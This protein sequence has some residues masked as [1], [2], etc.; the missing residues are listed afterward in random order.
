MAKREI[1]MIPAT[2]PKFTGK[3]T[4]PGRKRR[5]AAYARVS[6]DMEEQQTSYEAQMDYYEKYIIARSDWDF[7]GLYSDEGI[8]GTS[9]KYRTGFNQMIE[10]ALAGKIDLIVTKSISRFARNTVDSLVTIRK[11][12]EHG[13]EC[14][15][16][17]ENIYTFDSKGELLITIMSSIAQEESR[18]I[19]ENVTWG[20]R[21]R[22]ADGKVSMPYK[23][24]LG[25]S[26]GPDGLPQVVEKEAAVVRSIYLMFLEGYSPTY[27]AKTLT[28]KGIP[29]PAG[30]KRWQN[31]TVE[32]ILRNEKYKGDALLQK[33]F[34]VDF[35]T[36]KMKTNEGEIPQ[37]YVTDS[38]EGIISPEVFELA[39]YEFQCR[40]ENGGSQNHNV[41]PFSGH[42]ICGECGAYYGHKVWHSNDKYRRLVWLC[43]KKYGKGAGDG[44]RCKTPHLTD[45]EVKTF[46]VGAMNAA[47][48][49]KQEILDNCRTAVEFLTDT[50]QLESDLRK[51]E[52]ECDVATG[53]L[54]KCIDENAH[55]AISQEDYETKYAALAA[56][57]EA[58]KGKCDN[59]NE[60]ILQR[61]LKANRIEAF[62]KTMETSD[63]VTEFDEGLWN[64]TVDSL[65]VYSKK[66]IVLKLKDGTEIEWH[67]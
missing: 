57:Y 61:K 29:T 38:H 33:R 4:M 22:F 18:S 19:S 16:E 7:A 50:S 54:R 12:K 60:K 62:F 20:Q 63:I 66:K 13:V 55:A 67:I 37:Y 32:S 30:K 35:L 25:Y 14:F 64:A 26:K 24:F 27:I 56:R 53:L 51:L 17:K 5:V 42:I 43:N 11:L 49:N 52:A 10:D 9:T 40:R 34:T 2:I 3:H 41:S 65:T 48:S 44:L 1:T 58:A 8:S 59:M 31:S 28:S 36:K 21:K 46:F 6:T 23:H 39:Q 45:D 47:L 15:F